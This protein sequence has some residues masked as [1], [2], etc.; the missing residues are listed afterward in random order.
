MLETLYD[1]TI[2]IRIKIAINPC[3][4]YS[5]KL[6]HITTDVVAHDK[7]FF[8]GEEISVSYYIK[9]AQIISSF[10]A[11][12]NLVFFQ[13]ETQLK[14]VLDCLVKINEKTAEKAAHVR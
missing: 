7:L 1:P 13:S 2:L 8:N 6:Y 3:H 12:S 5:P 4:S 9:V 11:H 10:S 14:F